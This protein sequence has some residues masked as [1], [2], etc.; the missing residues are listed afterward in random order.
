LLQPAYRNF[1]ENVGLVQL[2]HRLLAMT[3]ITGYTGCYALARRAHVWNQLPPQ[4]RTA[5]NL[6]M[7]AVTGQVALGIT[8]LLQYVPIPLAIAHQSGA[9]VVLTSSLWTMHTMNFARPA[10]KAAVQAITKLA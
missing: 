9:M 2:D 10:A 4:T 6:T 5:L 3:T 8:T 7:A 1:F